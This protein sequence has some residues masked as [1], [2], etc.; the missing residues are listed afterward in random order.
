MLICLLMYEKYRSIAVRM[1]FSFGGS[2]SVHTESK[3]AVS[4][5][6]FMLCIV[7]GDLPSWVFK[8][9]FAGFSVY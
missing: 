3:Y 5:P 8:I 9:C 7:M 2:D 6:S 1:F 4:V